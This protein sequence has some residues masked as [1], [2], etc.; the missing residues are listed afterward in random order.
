MP[1]LREVVYNS[2]LAAVGVQNP[3]ENP[4][5]ALTERRHGQVP[6][7]EEACACVL[8]GILLFQCALVIQTHTADRSRKLCARV[9]GVGVGFVEMR[10]TL[11][12]ERFRDQLFSPER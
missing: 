4:I 8:H 11:Q 2:T 7:E 1:F 3:I 5:R 10:K 9:P 6:P 12:P